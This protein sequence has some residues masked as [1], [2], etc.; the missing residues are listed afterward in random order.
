MPGCGGFL[1]TSPVEDLNRYYAP[2]REVGVFSSH[3]EL[4]EKIRYYQ[5]HEDERSAIARA[6]YER[7]IREHIYVHR[8]TEI[9]R[10]IGL[11]TDPPEEILARGPRAGAVNPDYSRRA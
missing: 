11:P 6:G 8:F 5:D 10:R 1:L 4:V 3:D 2:G 7:T 9:V